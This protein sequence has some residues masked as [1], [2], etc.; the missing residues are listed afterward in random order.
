MLTLEE[1]RRKDGHGIPEF[2]NFYLFFVTTGIGPLYRGK[3]YFKRFA[4]ENPAMEQNLTRQV[5]AAMAQR[6]K[7]TPA[8]LAPLE[9]MLYQSY[10]IISGY[11][12]SDRDLFS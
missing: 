6:D 10:E 1:F 4:D 8:R 12:V 5:T 3:E 7:P 9:E 2:N 11:G